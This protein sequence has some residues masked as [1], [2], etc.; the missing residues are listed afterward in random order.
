MSR[1]TFKSSV[2]N[3]EVHVWKATCGSAIAVADDASTEG[4]STQVAPSDA[5]ALALAIL[6][7]AGVKPEHPEQAQVSF[8]STGHLSQIVFELGRFVKAEAMHAEIAREQAV[9]ETEALELMNVRFE[10]AGMSLRVTKETANPTA[11][12][13]WVTVA[14]RAREIAGRAEL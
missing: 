2:S 10:A 7:A 14:R 6:E 8:G 12:A 3:R 1:K 11:L 4:M 13:E 5:P 9:L